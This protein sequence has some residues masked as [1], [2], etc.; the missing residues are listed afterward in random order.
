[1][2]RSWWN[3]LNPLLELCKSGLPLMIAVIGGKTNRFK[4]LVWICIENLAEEL[5]TFQKN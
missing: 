2:D 1:M 3:T 5:K 4:P